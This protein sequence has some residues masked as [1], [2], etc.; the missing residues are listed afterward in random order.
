MNNTDIKR[1]LK[2]YPPSEYV[3]RGSIHYKKRLYPRL[4]PVS[5]KQFKKIIFGT[6][7]IYLALSY[8]RKSNVNQKIAQNNSNNITLIELTKNSF[9]N[10]L[11]TTGFLYILDKNKF[12]KSKLKNLHTEYISEKI[13]KPIDIIKINNPLQ[14]LKNEKS[15]K[16]LHCN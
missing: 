6:S 15:V 2:K 9:K 8:I 7:N 13:Q 16:L 1:I 3:Y 14:I 12:K 11:S 4:Y 10:S 5:K